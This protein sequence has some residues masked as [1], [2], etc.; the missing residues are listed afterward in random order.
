MREGYHTVAIDALAVGRQLHEAADD[1][2]VP[3]LLPS[4]P[5]RAPQKSKNPLRV[6]RRIHPKRPAEISTARPEIGEP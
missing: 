5:H 1:L 2:L 6:N 4:A 3:L